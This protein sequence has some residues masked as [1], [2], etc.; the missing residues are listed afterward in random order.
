MPQSLLLTAK[1]MSLGGE[2]A[3]GSLKTFAAYDTEKKTWE[4][5]PDYP[6]T[7]TGICKAR[8]VCLQP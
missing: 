1:S 5:L 4:S 6:G 8:H 2:N 7:N 3:T